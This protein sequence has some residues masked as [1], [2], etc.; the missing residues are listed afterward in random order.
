MKLFFAHI[1]ILSSIS[2]AADS[3]LK[4]ENNSIQHTMTD[5]GVSHK[6]DFKIICVDGYKFIQFKSDKFNTPNRTQILHKDKTV[7]KI[8]PVSCNGFEES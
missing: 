4:F 6:M 2:L 7:N 1:L 8:V 5:S 3:K